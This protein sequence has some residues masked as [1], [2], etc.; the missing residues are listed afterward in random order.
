[1]VI[2]QPKKFPMNKTVMIYTVF[3]LVDAAEI[4][5]RETGLVSGPFSWFQS[6]QIFRETHETSKV[7]FEPDMSELPSIAIA[8][9]SRIIFFQCIVTLIFCV[10]NIST[11]TPKKKIKF[12]KKKKELVKKT[13]EKNLNR[14]IN[15]VSWS[16]EA[17]FS[18]PLS[19]NTFFSKTKK[20]IR[21]FQ[22]FLYFFENGRCCN[23][24]ALKYQRHVKDYCF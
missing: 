12:C 14:Y 2:N 15:L 22:K 13:G 20:K 24:M 19:K 8:D 5:D 16:R 3:S 17:F 21:F 4:R 23:K 11:G 7:V 1:M 9:L 10:S 18:F 6:R